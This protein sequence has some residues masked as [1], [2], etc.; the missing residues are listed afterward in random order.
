M[1]RIGMSQKELR[2]VE[3]LARVK[4]KELKVVDAASVIRV[5]YRQGKRLWKRYR[6]EGAQGL[7]HGHAGRVS[8][9]AKPERFRRRGLPLVRG[10]GGEGGG[11]RG[12]ALGA[13]VGGRALGQGRRV[14][15]RRGDAAALDAGGRAVEP[16][17]PA[18]S[19]SAAARATAAL[20]GVGADGRKFPRLVGG[21]WSGRLPDEHDRR[22]HQ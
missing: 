9:R 4:S 3:V 2:R 18:E 22:C 1:G 12:R 21:A 16:A 8:A 19:V 17:A 11:S 6:E 10:E 20:W 13:D 15:D 7:R 5:S 14:A